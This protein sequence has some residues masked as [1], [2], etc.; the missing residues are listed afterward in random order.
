MKP[1]GRHP[2]LALTDL[3]VRKAT[4]PGRYADGNG[5][6]LLIDANGA[7][8]WIL[9]TVIRGKRTDM[10]LGSVQLVSLEE[11]RDKARERRKV[12]R[13]G[14]DPLALARAA[15]RVVP[16]FSE[17]ARKI[18]AANAASWRNAKHAAQWITSLETYAFPKLGE[19]PIDGISE[20]DVIEVLA[21]IWTAKRETADR[22][23]QRIATVF[24]WAKAMGHRAHGLERD[25]LR[26]ALGKRPKKRAAVR[27]HPALPYAELPDF[28]T[29]LRAS[30]AALAVR[31]ALEFLILTATRTGEVIGAKP[32]EISGD[33]WTIPADR[34]KA[35][36]AHV[37]PLSPR[38]LEIIEAAKAL[39][40]VYLFPG[41]RPENPLSNMSMLMAMRR[42]GHTAVPHGMRSTFRDW[43]ADRTQ[44]PAE[45]VEAALAH[46]IPDAVIAAYKRTNFYAKRAE[47]MELWSQYA[48]DG[49]APVVQL[50]GRA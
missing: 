29:A 33:R 35:G 39:G 43:A 28:V 42:M 38:C 36:V 48:T 11:A 2:K 41:R 1:R 47:L 30:D 44:F 45:V 34:M 10:G 20:T 7:K 6:Y 5:L 15:R 27:H 50:R 25:A 3:K 32:E 31:L 17:A 16:T 23:A 13:D 46:T 26:K 4:R 21:P 9:R 12:A 14:G 18:H 40:G 24:D 37:V 8:R 22:V 19:R 49:K